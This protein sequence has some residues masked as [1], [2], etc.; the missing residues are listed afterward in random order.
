MRIPVT[1]GIP[2]VFL[3]L[4]TL[5]AGGCRG[6]D[7]P[8]GLFDGEQVSAPTV[9][10]PPPGFVSLFDGRTLDGWKGLVSPEGG[11]PARA[12]LSALQLAAAQTA[13]DAK[14]RQHWSIDA[15]GT[16]FF[17]GKGDSL[18]TSR[19]YT[20]FELIVDWMIPPAGDSGIY[21]RGSPQVQIWET[22]VGS[23]GLYNNLKNEN[24]PDEK[25]DRPTGRWNRFFI[26]MRGERVW[27][28]LNGVL[29]TDG[30]V[31]ENYWERKKPI[32]PSG[33]IELQSHGGPLW[34]RNIWIRELE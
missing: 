25:A 33:Q 23:G 24:N 5:G 19:D 21:L 31:M 8:A 29:V 4:I 2:A 6:G 30:V 1:R 3:G 27:V 14:M 32:Y 11:P 28:W 16:L 15:D 18:C 34:F 17:D 7:P 10:P 20:D 26:R 9:L 13:A 12:K 22:V